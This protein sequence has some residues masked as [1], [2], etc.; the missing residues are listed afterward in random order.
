MQIRDR[1][2]NAFEC[3]SNLISGKVVV[4]KDTDGS[5]VLYYI[6]DGMRLL[7]IVAKA[8]GL[9]EI[10]AMQYAGGGMSQTQKKYIKW[11]R[12]GHAKFCEMRNVEIR[13][14]TI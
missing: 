10:N 6:H 2:T 4:I 8:D 14:A 5:I 12:E 11:A 3:G 1:I 9:F 7:K 13:E